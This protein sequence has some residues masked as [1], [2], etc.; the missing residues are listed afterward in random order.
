VALA[1]SLAGCDGSRATAP[2]APTTP[3]RPTATLSGLVF[4]AT[5]TGLH[6]VAGARVRLE[7]G[8]YRQDALTDQNG[9]YSLTE[10]YDGPS[11]VTTTLDG[12]D[13]DTRTITVSGS[14]ALDIAVT[15]RVR[16]TLSGEVY[17]LTVSGRVPLDGVTVRLHED[18]DRETAA[19]GAFTFT[20][21]F[22]GVWTLAASKSGYRDVFLQTTV[23]GDT[24]IDIQLVKR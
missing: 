11:T 13:T 9:R 22:N 17:E 4:T 16:H 19:D 8:S 14:V 12:Y 5:P 6:P 23:R 1:A 20:D 21:L 24:R 10:L 3:T 7:I 18:Y 2:T 15:A